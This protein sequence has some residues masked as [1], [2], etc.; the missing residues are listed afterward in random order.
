MSESLTA[1]WSHISMQ[2][3]HGIERLTIYTAKD[4]KWHVD[5][6]DL[7]VLRGASALR[8]NRQMV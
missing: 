1:A 4:S 6:L 8:A 3:L 7:L 5:L 2:G